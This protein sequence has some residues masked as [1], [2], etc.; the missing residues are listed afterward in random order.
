MSRIKVSFLLLLIALSAAAGAALKHA[1]RAAGTFDTE[2]I[3]KTLGVKGSVKDGEYKVAIP[4]RDLVVVVDGFRIT[5]PMGLT[6]WAGFSPMQ[7]GAL[8]MGD[9]VMRETEVGPVEKEV[10]QRGLSVTGLHN[11]FLRENERVMYMHIHGM[12]P[13]KEMAAGVRAILDKV[14]ELRHG[15]PASGKSEPVENHIDT[16]R[17]ESILGHK[18]EL[19]DGVFKITIGRPDVALKDHGMPVSAFMGFNTWAAFQG[20]E[21]KAAVAGD[22]AMLDREVEP[23]MAALAEH[24]IE[25][26]AMHNHM[27]TETP[28]IFFLHYWGEGPADKLAEGLQSALKKTGAPAD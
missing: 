18:G 26:V 10:I 3:E 7:D 8:V 5:P 20:T 21:G 25:V 14:S 24:G 6:T 13:T 27:V 2:M 19:A 11:H 9:I 1:A 23:V 16:A 4:Q 28:R 22:F 15:N 12:G 17:I